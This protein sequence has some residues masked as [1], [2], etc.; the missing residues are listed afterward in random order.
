[1]G[2]EPHKMEICKYKCTTNGHTNESESD[3][4][5]YFIILSSKDYNHW[6]NCIT[7]LPLTTQRRNNYNNYVEGLAPENVKENRLSDIRK[8]NV[9]CD[10]PCRVRKSDNSDGKK[11]GA[12]RY[13]TFKKIVEKVKCFME[14]DNSCDFTPDNF[15][16]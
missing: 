13:K 6:S 11:Y 9:L 4:P 1:M 10:R 15:S 5:H 14:E 7:V 16:G 3:K 12:L 2:Y 8:T